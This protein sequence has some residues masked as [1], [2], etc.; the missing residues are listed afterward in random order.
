MHKYTYQ[1]LQQPVLEPVNYFPWSERDQS[2]H[3]GQGV[4]F[5]EQS[6]SQKKF[7]AH[8]HGKSVHRRNKLI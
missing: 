2:I 1:Y 8:L 4:S 7:A 5:V 6:H 3:T